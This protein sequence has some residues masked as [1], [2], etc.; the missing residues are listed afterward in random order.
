MSN[1]SFHASSWFF[2]VLIVSAG[3]LAY[4]KGKLSLEASIGGILVASLIFV[5]A[6][7]PALAMLAAFFGLGTLATSHRKKDKIQTVAQAHG[8]R[9]N[10]GQVVANAGV[11]SIL[12]IIKIITDEHDP[13]LLA[14][15]AGSFSS[16]TGDTL[17]SELGNVYGRNFYHVLSFRKD[18][19][20]LDGVISLEGTLFG[21]FGSLVIA[22]I[23]VVGIGWS[24]VFFII[25]VAGVIG[26]LSDS[27]LGAS[28][29]RK[30]YIGNDTVN[31]LNTAIGA[32]V[33]LLLMK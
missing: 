28:L 23:Y 27:I 4:K 31:F 17:S 33:V 16:A 6:G 1:I 3:M 19:R 25:T 29:E 2:V 22:I 12:A 14:M 8:E 10:L 30:G 18:K 9:R 11:A 26:N 13:L 21:L 24:N 15:I 20:G 7:L 32:T 5:S